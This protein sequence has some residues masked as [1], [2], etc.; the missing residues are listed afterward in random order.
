MKKQY[1]KP[2]IIIED[3]RVTQHIAS[4]A[5]IKHENDIGTPLQWSKT[6][7]AWQGP[8]GEMLF[9]TGM[10]KCTDPLGPKDKNEI[11]CYNAPDGSIVIFGS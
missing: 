4:C 2:E 1:S 3:F 6:S 5:G 9:S 7:C 8:F 11:I 10:N